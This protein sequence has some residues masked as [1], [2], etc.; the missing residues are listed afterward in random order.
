MPVP[1]TT[2]Q[3]PCRDI[4]LT[5][6]HAMIERIANPSLPSR[7]LLLTPRLVIRESCGA[8]LH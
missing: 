3:Q 2:I 1:L 6:F 8:Y 7:S 4:A 5:S